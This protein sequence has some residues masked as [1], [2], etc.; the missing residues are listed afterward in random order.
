MNKRIAAIH[1]AIFLCLTIRHF[2]NSFPELDVPAYLTLRPQ[3]A[4]ACMHD[5]VAYINANV[6]R[7]V[8][9]PQI[10]YNV[11]ISRWVGAEDYSLNPRARDGKSE[12][13]GKRGRQARCAREGKRGTEGD[14][15]I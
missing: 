8:N 9:S 6:P 14:G 7:P 2:S 4:N 5:R 10:P 11:R 1:I 12:R 13:P 15:A 3:G